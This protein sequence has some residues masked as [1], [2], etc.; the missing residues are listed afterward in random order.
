M[1][2][3]YFLFAAQ[4]TAIITIIILSN[5][6]WYVFRVSATTS[7]PMEDLEATDEDQR[8]L[9][10]AMLGSCRCNAPARSSCFRTKLTIGCTIHYTGNST[11]SIMY[12]TLFL[13]CG[14]SSILG[15][16]VRTKYLYCELFLSGL[17]TTVTVQRVAE[18]KHRCFLRSS[19]EGD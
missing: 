14:W 4:H 11:L 7:S 19:Q 5:K 1:A 18:H 16:R 9:F 12:T 3:N 15:H 10:P 8:T 17:P 2:A 6:V 13:V